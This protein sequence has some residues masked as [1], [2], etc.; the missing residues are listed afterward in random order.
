MGFTIS[1]LDVQSVVECKPEVIERVL[2]VVK[3]KVEAFM[4]NPE[5]FTPE[6]T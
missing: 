6:K 3:V 1:Q 5:G 4:N 2:K